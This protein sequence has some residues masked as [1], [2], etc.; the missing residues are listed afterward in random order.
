ML[1]RTNERRVS[2]T[3]ER[4][5]RVEEKV[6]KYELI[7]RP[8]VEKRL[9]KIFQPGKDHSRY[10]VVCGEQCRENDIG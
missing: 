6:S 2:K 10:H 7:S 8:D 1:D 9:K 4:G 3:L 5:T